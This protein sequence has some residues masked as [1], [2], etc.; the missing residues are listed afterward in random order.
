M[1]VIMTGWMQ[2][3]PQ[4]LEQ[5]A[6]ENTDKMHSIIE[7]AKQHGLIAHRFYGTAGQIMVVDEWPD[8][9][10]FHSFFAEHQDKIGPLMQAAGITSEPAFNFW[11]KLDT[12]DE[13][14]WES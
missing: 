3:D 7:G 6:A 8:E 4:K 12:H 11:T 14:G 13:F 10:S 5:Y 1:S 2:G 9:Q